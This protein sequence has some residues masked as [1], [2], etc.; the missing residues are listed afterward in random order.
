MDVPQLFIE[1]TV[2][3]CD[4]HSDYGYSILFCDCG[5]ERMEIYRTRYETNR[6]S[7]RTEGILS[8]AQERSGPEWRVAI[9]L[10]GGGKEML[11]SADGKHWR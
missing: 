9:D 8:F 6:L 2:E 4:G 11:R 7:E 3:M 1:D 5:G 10:V